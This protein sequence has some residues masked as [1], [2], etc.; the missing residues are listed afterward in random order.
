MG[1]RNGTRD[2][3][4]YTPPIILVKNTW[5]IRKYYRW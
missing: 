3:L 1:V 2:G 5:W 4:I